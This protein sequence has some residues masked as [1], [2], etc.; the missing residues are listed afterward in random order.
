MQCNGQNGGYLIVY[1]MRHS[2]YVIRSSGFG[3]RDLL[4]RT[5]GAC[6]NITVQ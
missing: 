3:F 4:E 2:L 5:E 1:G 6:R